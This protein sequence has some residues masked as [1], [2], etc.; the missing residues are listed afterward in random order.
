[1]MCGVT[2][3][4]L[5]RKEE[6]LMRIAIKLAAMVVAV[7]CIQVQ[8]YEAGDWIVR[9]GVAV[10]E[11]NEDND[12]LTAGGAAVPGSDI[13]IDVDT[14]LGLTISYMVSDNWGLELLG[15]TP[16]EHDVTASVPGVTPG[17][18][19]LA[20]IKHLPPTLSALW[21]P[22]DKNSAIQPFFGLGVTYTVFWD[23]D[24]SSGAESLLGAD[25]LE[26]DDTIGLSAR[27]G[28][29]Y[30][31][32]DNWLIHAGVWYLGIETDAS[33]DTALGKVKVDVDVNPWTYMVS[34][35]YKF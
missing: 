22:M 9:A 7:S 21:Y 10:V 11:P 5:S 27:V 32:N 18:V 2:N 13:G 26:L 4:L 31:L 19:D 16:F 12:T 33:M 24:L 6:L 1:M 35:G 30:R 3:N 34:V 14:K 15:A 23:E 29:D 8:A 28:V 25:N 17:K 20:S